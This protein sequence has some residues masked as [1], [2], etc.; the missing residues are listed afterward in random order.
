MI[1]QVQEQAKQFINFIAIYWYVL[2]LGIWG[3]LVSLINRVRT[4][5]AKSTFTFIVLDVFTFTFVATLVFL[6]C[7]SLK[8]DI[9]LMA[10]ATA[11]GGHI[12][13]RLMPSVEVAFLKKIGVK[14]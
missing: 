1:E 8:L 3:G 12:G 10:V 14:T 5:Q 6:I 2:A 11:I 13:G 4:G 7:I 9:Y